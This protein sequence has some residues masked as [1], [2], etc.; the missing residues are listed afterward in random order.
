MVETLAAR[1]N[2]RLFFHC[3]WYRPRRLSI[4]EGSASTAS[5][6]AKQYSQERRS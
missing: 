3:N 4:L 2:S 5:T 1:A 6:A